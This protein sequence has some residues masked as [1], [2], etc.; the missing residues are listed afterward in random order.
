MQEKLISSAESK[1]AKATAKAKEL[2]VKL[3]EAIRAAEETP[4]AA[5]PA[6]AH[7]LEHHSHK[8]SKG[9]SGQSLVG[10]SIPCHSYLSSQR[11][12]MTANKGISV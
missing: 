5:V 3:A 9:M 6:S 1:A 7:D 11:K 4:S 8:K 10:A 2:Q 12:G